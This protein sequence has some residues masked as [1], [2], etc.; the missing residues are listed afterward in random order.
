MR[1]DDKQMQIEQ[2]LDYR[3]AYEP[4]RAFEIVA[5]RAVLAA[6]RLDVRLGDQSLTPVPV[7]DAAVTG[8][9]VRL[10]VAAPADQIGL[11]QLVCTYVMPMPA[12]DRQKSLRLV[13]PLVVPADMP[14]LQIG[15]QQ[16]E[17]TS[18]DSWQ[19]NPDPEGVSDEFSRFSRMSSGGPF[20]SSRITSAPRWIIEPAA[21]APP[22]PIAI[23]KAWVQTWLAGGVRHERAVFRLLTDQE[24]VRI[25]LPASPTGGSVQAAINAQPVAA[26]VRSPP[27]VRI[28]LPAAARGRECVLELWY[29]TAAP[30]ARGGFTATALA[31]AK[32]EGASAPR[33]LFWQ[34]CLP[35]DEHLLAPPGELAAEMT[36]GRT[37]WL[38]GRRATLGQT[39]LEAWIGASRQDAL[40]SGVNEY[41][42]SALARSP[43]LSFTAGGRRWLLFAASGLV[44]AG[45]LILMHV[46][47]VRRP[48]TLFVAGAWRWPC[49]PWPGPMLRCCSPRP[50]RRG[51]S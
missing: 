16:L 15:G 22:A 30:A 1:L 29:S 41:L 27:S 4:Q 7:N 20:M 49:W 37:D 46:R 31:P 44:L 3:I 24:Q 38:W 2:R 17:F 35:E 10:Q 39:E 28:D 32:I 8:D 14:N 13:V 25:D 5:P 26:A 51:W 34:L 45:G 42:F 19:L 43:K 40:P 11:C 18:A 47:V 50:P 6:G 33:R 48:E 36:W 23:S 9:G 21:S 12:W